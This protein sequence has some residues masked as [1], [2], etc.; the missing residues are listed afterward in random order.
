MKIFIA[1]DHRGYKLK[2]RIYTFL[3]EQNYDIHDLSKPDYDPDDDNP[4]FGQAVAKEIQK[5]P[6]NNRG[7]IICGSGVGISISAN[8]FKHVYTALGFDKKQVHD[9][10]QHDFI[11]VLS[12]AADFIEADQA[13][14]LVE[15]FLS[16]E[17][18]SKKR[19]VDRKYMMDNFGSDLHEKVLP[20]PNEHIA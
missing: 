8:R 2:N 17:E 7:I 20:D 15:T 19:Y 10:R 14:K 18:S 3:K 1:A 12:L 6:Q 9:A 4:I 5:D 13:I 11:N 16:T